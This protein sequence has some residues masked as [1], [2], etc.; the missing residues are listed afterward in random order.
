LRFWGALALGLDVRMALVGTVCTDGTTTWWDPR[1]TAKLTNA[2]MQFVWAH[3]IM[4]CALKH[5]TRQG[6][7]R[8][9]LWNVAC[10]HAI[11]LLLIQEK[12]TM[13]KEGYRDPRFA[14]MTAER[15][16]DQLLEEGAAEPTMAGTG[17][18]GA[19]DPIPSGDL[20]EGGVGGF[21]RPSELRTPAEV[22]KLESQWRDNVQAAATAAMTIGQLSANLA[23]IVQQI[24]NPPLPWRVILQDFIDRTVKSTYD[25]RRPNRRFLHSGIILPGMV[26][27]QVGPLVVVV[28]TSGS[29]TQKVL[30]RFAHEINAMLELARPTVIRVYYVD[31]KVCGMEEFSP[32][33]EIKLHPN[34]GGG[35]SFVPAFEALEEEGFEPV[36]LIY[37]TDLYTKS[38]PKNTP[39]FP[40]LWVYQ[41]IDESQVKNYTPPFGELM[42]LN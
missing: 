8:Q 10:D 42:P 19:G 17:R 26:P 35:T 33:D 32:D 16:Y 4:H 22:E 40:V 36:A 7:R 41:G 6:S 15:I 14:N 24:T 31:A 9:G 5:I 30:G 25:W 1:W 28:D 37:L 38:Y 12:F 2:E 39:D 34:G 29:I 18:N 20:A 3:E 27:D 11:N 13:P 23:R 21:Y